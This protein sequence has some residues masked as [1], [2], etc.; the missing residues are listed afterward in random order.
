MHSK[1]YRTVK[2][3]SKSFRFKRNTFVP[4]LQAS[5]MKTVRTKGWRNNIMLNVVMDLSY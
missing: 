5:Q 3:H 2:Y 1:D 4:L